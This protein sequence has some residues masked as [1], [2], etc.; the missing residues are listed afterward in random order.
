MKQLTKK[1]VVTVIL[2][3][4]FIASFS[5]FALRV[6]AQTNS[7]P[8]ASV[9]FSPSRISGT[10][11][12]TV[13]VNL[14]VSSIQ[15]VS[16]FGAGLMFNHHTAQCTGVTAGSF[17]SHNGKYPTLFLPGSID[18]NLGVVEVSSVTLTGTTTMNGSGTLLTFQFTMNGTGTSYSDLHIIDFEA[19]ATDGS[20]IPC[21]TIDYFT[22][23]P[24]PIVQIVGNPQGGVGVNPYPGFNYQNYTTINQSIGGTTYNRNMSFVI[25]S[26]DF[27]G[28]FGF[29]NVTISNALMSGVWYV[30]L[31]GVVQTPLVT[32]LNSTFTI[33]S[34]QFTYGSSTVEAVQILSIFG[35]IATPP[36]YSGMTRST[37]YAGYPCTFN[38]TW[39]DKVALNKYIFSFDNGVG[40][41]TNDTATAFTSNP[42]MISVTKTLTANVG[43]TVR[44]RWYAVDSSNKWNSTTI[45]T[46]VT[47]DGTPPT[48]ASI[49][50]STTVAGNP[51][52][53][54]IT[55]SDNAGL[56]KY[57]FS[58][59]NGIGSFTNSTALAFTSNPQTIS[60]TKTLTA[61]VGATIRFR[62][63]FND[64]SNNWNSTATQSFTATLVTVSISP[65]SGTIDFGQSQLFT[66]TVSG[67]IPP[68]LYQWYM[69][70][71]GV[72][73]AVFSSWMFTPSSAGTYIIFLKVTDTLGTT[74]ESSIAMLVVNPPLTILVSPTSVG[75]EI[76]EPWTFIASISNGT[77]PYSYTSGTSM[78]HQ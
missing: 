73:G 53:F 43:A 51:C 75:L 77:P 15:R 42:Q 66:S 8:T 52:T 23:S 50:H 13:S 33:V 28:N 60:V 76:G 37:S 59:D 19:L 27:P 45:Q 31:N 69:N 7:I 11:G 40:S 47:K 39:Q 56:S 74:G 22:T 21:K 5:P 46:F 48:Y 68:Y 36:T 35:A 55:C 58:F 44:Y 20:N 78:A 38:I 4:L 72:T 10:S 25:L 32:I 34:L 24:G 49:T 63:F 29:F 14:N 16:T 26:P 41:F 2:C 18:N 62:W 71:T 70:G 67:G 64:T 3:S 17:M 30:T 6:N 54:S 65:S 57:I 12:T 9:F 1:Q 61:T